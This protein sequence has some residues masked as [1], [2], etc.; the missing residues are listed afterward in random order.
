MVWE[1]KW[2]DARVPYVNQ[3]ESVR[4]FGA[5]DS[6]GNLFTIQYED[7]FTADMFRI[8]LNMLYDKCGKFMIIADG[9]KAH[10]ANNVKEF[11]EKKGIDLEILPA[12]R[13]ELNAIETIWYMGKKEHVNGKFYPDRRELVSKLNE[14]F[15]QKFDID[16]VKYLKRKVDDYSDKIN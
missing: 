5:L 10:T 14:F 2:K 7:N 11:C 9:A 8:C 4:Y 3:Y 12:G 13:P 6:D 16:L 15:S 1:F